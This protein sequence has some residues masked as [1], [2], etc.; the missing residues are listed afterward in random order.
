MI[1]ICVRLNLAGM[2]AGVFLRRAGGSTTL[3]E[4]S[5]E[6]DD[7]GACTEGDSSN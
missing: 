2:P 7:V 1:V 4:G 6:D 5:M 3:R